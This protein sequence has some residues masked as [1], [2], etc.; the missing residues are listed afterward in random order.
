[1]K[2]NLTAQMK[3]KNMKKIIKCAHCNSEFSTDYR[4]FKRYCSAYCNTFY[5]IEEKKGHYVAMGAYQVTHDGRG[6]NLRKL[7]Y[8]V[9]NDLTYDDVMHLHLSTTCDERG[10]VKGSHT[11]K[12]GDY[13]ERKRKPITTTI[14]QEEEKPTMEDKKPVK[15][16]IEIAKPEEEGNLILKKECNECVKNIIKKLMELL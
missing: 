1:M 4:S 16:T 15:E 13:L 3:K 5:Y 7:H 11:L 12:A 14:N 2:G 9:E 8:A 6:Y 10:C